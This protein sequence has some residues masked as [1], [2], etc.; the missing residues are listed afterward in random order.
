MEGERERE[1]KAGGGGGEGL[2]KGKE[3]ERVGKKNM[4]KEGKHKESKGKGDKE[5]EEEIEI[6][7]LGWIKG[8]ER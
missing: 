6:E 3:G 8:E 7:D 5:T 1:G 4:I 2:I